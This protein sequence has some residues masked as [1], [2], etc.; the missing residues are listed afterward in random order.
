MTVQN[1]KSMIILG[2]LEVVQS[3]KPRSPAHQVPSH[4][5][6]DISTEKEPANESTSEDVDDT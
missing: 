5:V 1:G 2:K 4:Q 6:M 3:P